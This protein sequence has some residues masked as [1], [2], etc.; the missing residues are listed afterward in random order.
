ME[1]RAPDSRALE[2]FDGCGGAVGAS[3]G[4]EFREWRV[5]CREENPRRRRA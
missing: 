1:A 2:L 4:R 3:D 5:N